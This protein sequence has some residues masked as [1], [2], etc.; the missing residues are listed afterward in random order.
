LSQAAEADS[1][2]ARPPALTVIGAS[3][4]GPGHERSGTP[5][6]DAWSWQPRG[7]DS[8]VIAVADGLGS[9][10]RSE[11]GAQLAVSVAC[12]A[13]AQ[14]LNGE[15]TIGVLEAAVRTGASAAR[16]ALEARAREDDLPL[17]A[18]ACTLIVVAIQG[19]RAA[20]AH[21]GDGAVVA[22][23][24]D[25]IALVSAPDSSEYAN[26]VVPITG[27]RWSGSL[28]VSEPCSGVRSLAVF[29]DG[30]QRAALRKLPDGFAPHEPFFRPVFAYARGAAGALGGSEEIQELL[31]SA[32]LVKNS[33]DD[34]TLV[35]LTVPQRM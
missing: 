33:E 6:Q 10:A 9:A 5:C 18:L 22:D 4:R 13:A 17:S 21:I 11:V 1:L 25:G 2:D 35:L 27:E 19:D 34:K 3:V 20:A 30:C 14:L 12:H 7:S 26:E 32:K 31:S 15:G 23:A 16:R 28:R 8:G 29:T 24:A